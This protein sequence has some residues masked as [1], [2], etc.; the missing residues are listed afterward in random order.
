MDKI[1]TPKLAAYSFIFILVLVIVFHVLVLANVI[2]YQIVWGGRIGNRSELILF[3]VASITINLLMLSVILLKV[4]IIKWRVPP[5]LV[6]VALWVMFAIFVLNTLGNLLSIN[7]FE[8]WVFT[9]MT[10]LLALLSLKLALS[11]T[12]LP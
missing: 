7:S 11:K 5:K 12:S 6:T 3:E 2:P 1:S 4:K 10:L 8:K 9:P